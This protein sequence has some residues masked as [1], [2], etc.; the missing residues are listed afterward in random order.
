MQTTIFEVSILGFQIA[1]KW[2]GAMYAFGFLFCYMFMG[3]WSRLSRPEL[4]SLL[5]YVFL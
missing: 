4:E 1:P 5:S 3:R 2:Y